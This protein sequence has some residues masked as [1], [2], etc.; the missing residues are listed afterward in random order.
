MGG[1]AL[2]PPP[3]P[4]F[5]V[6]L[7]SEQ[8]GRIMAGGCWSELRPFCSGFGSRP[9]PG[10]PPPKPG[11][12]SSSGPGRAGR[13]SHKARKAEKT[14]H[15]GLKKLQED[16]VITAGQQLRVVREQLGMTLRDVEIASGHIA[17]HHGNDNF[18][19]SPS[20]LS[21]IETKGGLPSIF[22]LHTLAVV[23]RRDV[24]EILSWY[25]IEVNES[26]V[27]LGLMAPPRSHRAQTLDSAT[28]VK[29][30][31]R[32]DPSFDPRRAL[33]RGGGGAKG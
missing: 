23:Y 2:S 33:N 29:V 16:S 22:R 14:T 18:A 32:L 12:R 9:I 21:D 3:E 24:R 15:E 1:R 26:A 28:M 27:D 4:A 20:R 31:V 6:V 7:K 11:R 13:T 10:S 5:F 8:D 25:G 30:P 19:L 17:A